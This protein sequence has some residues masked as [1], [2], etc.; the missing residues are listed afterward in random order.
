[1]VA[2]KM[3]HVL[4]V[5]SCVHVALWFDV[6]ISLIYGFIWFSD[7]LQIECLRCLAYQPIGTA[8]FFANAWI[9]GV[10]LAS[11]DETG[12]LQE[13]LK[14]QH[15]D[16]NAE[17]AN[18][19][20][21][22]AAQNNKMS[23]MLAKSL[24]NELNQLIADQ[25]TILPQSKRICDKTLYRSLIDVMADR[26]IAIRKSA[27][28]H[29][30]LKEQY[31]PSHRFMRNLLI[32]GID[33]RGQ[34]FRMRDVFDLRQHLS[35]S[36]FSSRTV[37][38]KEV[39]PSTLSYA[40]QAL[41]PEDEMLEKLNDFRQ[42]LQQK[43]ASAAG[44]VDPDKHTP[45]RL[46]DSP[47]CKSLVFGLVTNCLLLLFYCYTGSGL[48]MEINDKDCGKLCWLDAVDGLVRKF[49]G[50]LACAC[51]I[52][53]MIVII[54]NLDKL[55]PILLMKQNIE[56][57]QDVKRSM[58]QLNTLFVSGAKE[59]IEMGDVIHDVVKEKRMTAEFVR[60]L[61]A[62]EGHSLQVADFQEL[63]VQLR[64]NNGVFSSPVGLASSQEAAP[65]LQ[66]ETV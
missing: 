37:T 3:D 56:A 12:K 36:L 22:A 5:Q 58:E 45:G 46:F 6:V 19:T 33:D 9:A 27:T 10:L 54:A 50:I 61:A 38:L 42:G 62:R 26:L 8:I 39:S 63:F 51:Q 41:W 29:F 44:F 4:D 28:V 66:T 53:A 30:H 14:N 20:R 25:R 35:H 11:Y 24:L 7:V 55:D 43:G 23:G 47:M 17:T 52:G 65:L 16:L 64:R 21:E 13:Q 49:I 34:D 15:E 18:M 40:E 1:M 48:I 31:P 57:L 32:Q 60:K 59:N 2:I